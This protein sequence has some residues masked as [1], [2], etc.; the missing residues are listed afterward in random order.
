[1]NRP[2][3]HPSREEI[4]KAGSSL[5]NIILRAT[6]SLIIYLVFITAIYIFLAGHN[7]P[8]GGFSAGLMVSAGMVILYITFGQPFAINLPVD[9]KYF[10]PVGLMF[11]VGCGLGGVLFGYPFLTHTFAYVPIPVF[12]EIELT[13]ASIFDF[14]VALVVIGMVLTIIFSIGEN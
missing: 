7:Q 1:M 13:T 10:I 2:L 4:D 12:G 11:A 14:G 8:G 5:N 3:H 6:V 9:Y